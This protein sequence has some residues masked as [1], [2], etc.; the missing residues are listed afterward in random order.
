MDPSSLGGGYNL[1]NQSKSEAKTGMV[2]FGGFGGLT[3]N[4]HDENKVWLYVAA[5][6]LVMFFAA[7][8]LRGK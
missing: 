8:L 1:Q 2:S 7:P 4:A 3:F 5:A 6:A